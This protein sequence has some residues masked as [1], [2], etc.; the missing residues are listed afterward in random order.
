MLLLFAS[1]IMASVAYAWPEDLLKW[2][3]IVFEGRTAHPQLYDKAVAITFQHNKGLNRMAMI[4][5]EKGGMPDPIYQENQRVFSG[6][7]KKF[8]RQAAADVGMK[9]RLQVKK[10]GEV[11]IFK[12]GTDTDVIVES[13]KP[14][15]KITLKNVKETE[16]AYQR[17]VKNFLKKNGVE[18]PLGIIDT[19]TDFMPNSKDTT[20]DEFRKINKYINKN[21]GTA[22]ESPGAAEVEAKM[23]TKGATLKIGET[24]EYVSE[25]TRLIGKKLKY[26]DMLD[27]EAR[28]LAKFQP[29]R[30]MELQAEAQLARSQVGKYIQRIDD[31][32]RAVAKQHG[33][34]LKPNKSPFWKAVKKVN[35]V[36]GV[37]S[38]TEAATVSALGKYGA[39]KAL[40]SYAKTLAKIAAIGKA[41]LS[42]T[43][44]QIAET[45]AHLPPAAQGVF[46]QS[47]RNS[48]GDD[49]AR[50]I[51]A[52]LREV[53]EA[54]RAA[55]RKAASQGKLQRGLKVLGAVMIV[56]DGYGRIKAAWHAKPEDKPQVALEEG[57]SFVAG[58]A[59]AMSGGFLG[60]VA[61]GVLL[62]SWLPVAG[63]IIGGIV[64][65]VSGY[66]A[67]NY[68]GR[69]AGR[70]TATLLGINQQ[71][72]LPVILKA[73]Q[74]LYDGLLKRGVPEKIAK[75]AAQGLIQGPHKDFQKLMGFIRQKYGKSRAYVSVHHNQ[76]D[77]YCTNRPVIELDTDM[78]DLIR[79]ET[80]RRNKIRKFFGLPPIQTE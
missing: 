37:E 77:W 67:G 19:D 66:I 8:T 56:H 69:A 54:S 43:S 73:G 24:G 28:V 52:K 16:V 71:A 63:P 7:N 5:L 29:L 61:A 36:R 78:S 70:E 17:R 3:T 58:T 53:N 38:A 15:K 11:E 31:V 18:P 62:G 1:A 80:A 79:E 49:V 74:K 32:N 64:G 40:T 25:M 60:G 55:A 46:I 51:N 47:L 33:I 44:R 35:K 65:G 45:V 9:A 41:N 57:G 13:G 75:A 6:L 68:A 14:G 50:A 30:A 76:K 10:P 39:N 42:V 12:H 72:H 20:P 22:Y 21:G 2:A 26:A 59:G 23:R 34:T 27:Y 4:S 48:A